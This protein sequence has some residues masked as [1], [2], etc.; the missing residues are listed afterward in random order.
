MEI[1]LN[2]FNF[3]KKLYNLVPFQEKEINKVQNIVGDKTVIDIVNNGTCIYFQGTAMTI[4][5]M[6]DDWFV[7]KE[8]SGWGGFI[9]KYY[10]YDGFNELLSNQSILT[11]YKVNF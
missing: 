7:V 6:E 5:K 10:L 4:D 11:K 9:E 3:Y 1:D 2:K 8:L